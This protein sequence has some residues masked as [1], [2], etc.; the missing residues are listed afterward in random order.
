[1]GLGEIT[2]ETKY[3]KYLFYFFFTT[4][5]LR[6]LAVFLQEPGPWKCFCFSTEIPFLRTAVCPELAHSLSVTYGIPQAGRDS[7]RSLAQN[8]AKTRAIHEVKP[9]HSRL[10][11]AQSLKPPVKICKYY[12]N[13]C[14]YLRCQGQ[15]YQHIHRFIHFSYEVKDPIFLTSVHT[16][17]FYL[18]HLHF[19]SEG[20]RNKCN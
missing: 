17:G 19:N 9:S 7:R 18:F 15:M 13:K 6:I 4:I 12:P 2:G 11:P 10:H 14:F 16:T 5:P 8:P 3:R 1:M 20:I